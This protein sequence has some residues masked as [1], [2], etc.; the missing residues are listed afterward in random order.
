MPWRSN[1]R[2]NHLRLEARG[3]WPY[4]LPSDIS[5]RIFGIGEVL[6][7]LLPRGRQLG[8]A[9]ANFAFHARSLGL[10]A[11]VISCVGEDELGREILSRLQELQVPVDSVTRNMEL[12]TGTVSVMLDGRGVPH[13]TIHE[14]VAWDRIQPTPNTV[15]NVRRAE[16][17][18]FGSLA[19]RGRTSR[20][21]IQE[22]VSVAPE[23]ALRVFDINLRQEFYSREVIEQSL[24]LANVL[25]LND[26][27]LP[28]LAAMFELAGSVREQLSQLVKRFELQTVALTC[29]EKGSL[30]HHHGCW[31]ECSVRPVK[32][33]DTVGAGDA[34]T[35]ALVNG[36]L[37]G[38]D[39]DR[40]N[41]AANEVA[42]HICASAGATPRLP[43]ELHQ[44]FN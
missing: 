34:F 41:S 26:S 42:R 16:A 31:S 30:L 23:T 43:D 14:P 35:A 22:L 1:R 8:G 11:T 40:I 27:E 7:D 38:I 21:A 24:R 6:W 10:E 37:R 20:E 44:L 2:L 39:L 28:V 17:V 5:Q 32:V 29:G 4:G 36:L 25:K 19:Q 33:V 9:P 13:Y 18:C 15:E 3:V 12:P